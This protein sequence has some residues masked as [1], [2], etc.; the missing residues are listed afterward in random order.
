[1]QVVTLGSMTADA[2]ALKHQGESIFFLIRDC[3][4]ELNRLLSIMQTLNMLAVK[5]PK[6]WA[7]RDGKQEAPEYK[8]LMAAGSITEHETGGG[9]TNIDFGDLRNSAVYALNVIDN[10]IKQGSMEVVDLG[11]LPGPMS[12]V[13]LIEIGEGR[14]QVFLPRLAARGLLNQQI[15]DMFLRQITS[16]GERRV[17][18]GTSGRQRSFDTGKLKGAYEVVFKY[19]V[20]SPKIDV[21]RYSMA[22][23]AKTIGLPQEDIDRDVLQL[24]DPDGVKR[25]RSYET[26][27]KLSPLVRA[28]RI[29]KDLTDMEDDD[30]NLDAEILAMQF[31]VDIKNLRKSDGQTLQQPEAPAMGAQNLLPLLAQRNAV[32]AEPLKPGMPGNGGEGA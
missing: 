28:R 22:Q 14:D 9:A 12:A 20:K 2:D 24:E 15:A 17:E 5:P 25:R 6:G 21:A 29:I 16:C 18:L 4:P 23:V 32:Q 8:D 3:I 1:V 31:D 27:E 19:F 26:A 7:S 30:A 11:S 13:A 10:A